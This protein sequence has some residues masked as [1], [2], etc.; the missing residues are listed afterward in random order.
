MLTKSGG[1]IILLF[2]YSQQLALLHLSLS[3]SLCGLGAHGCQ[4]ALSLADKIAAK[5]IQEASELVTSEEATDKVYTSP[6]CT[7]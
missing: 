3:I 7:K 5:W 1:H 6:E 4:K 2:L